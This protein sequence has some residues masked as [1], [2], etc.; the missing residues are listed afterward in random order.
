MSVSVENE[1]DVVD[2]GGV[3]SARFMFVVVGSCGTGLMLA[4]EDRSLRVGRVE[5]ETEGHDIR[6]VAEYAGLVDLESWR[7][8][9]VRNSGS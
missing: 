6:E 3:V 7:F 2:S 1:R 8:L 4:D 5:G 9:K